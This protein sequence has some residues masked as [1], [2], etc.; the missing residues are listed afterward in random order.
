VKKQTGPAKSPM[1]NAPVQ[2]TEPAAGVMATKPETV[3][4]IM[5]ST[6]GRFLTIHSVTIQD[7]VLIAVDTCVTITP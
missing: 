2:S 3:P 5:P 6:D 1:K 7:R 4:L